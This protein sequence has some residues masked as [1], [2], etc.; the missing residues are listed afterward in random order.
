MPRFL[1][2][3]VSQSRTLSTT[4]ATLSALDRTAQD[5]SRSGAHLILFPEC[6][7]GGYPR[8][9]TF[10]SSV[11]ARSEHG[12]NQFLEHFHSAIDLGDTP[13]GAGEDWVERRLEMG[14]GRECRGDGTREILELVARNTGIFLVVGVVERAGGSLFCGAVYVCPNKGCVGKRRKVMPVSKL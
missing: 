7:L 9:C 5:A 13:G 12:R 14:K 3:A 2:L 8:T 10:G 6:Y 11:G 4:S 1:T